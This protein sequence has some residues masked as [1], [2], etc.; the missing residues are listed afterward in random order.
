MGPIGYSDHT[1]GVEIPIMAVAAG[2][3]LIEKHFTLDAKK[4][5]PDHAM[6]AEPLTLNTM[7][8]GVK[9]MERILG[10]AKMRMREI[11]ASAAEYRRP[12]I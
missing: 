3:Q 8:N 10:E 6:S 12:S 11:E 2:A 4:N 1:I 9:R 7:I 5:G